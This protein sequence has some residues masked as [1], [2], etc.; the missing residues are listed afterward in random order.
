M[1]ITEPEF[2]RRA[3]AARATKGKPPVAEH[4]PFADPPSRAVPME[5][6]RTLESSKFLFFVTLYRLK[7]RKKPYETPVL[8]IGRTVDLHRICEVGLDREF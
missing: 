4:G 7:L 1:T 8:R 5:I 2:E 3:N 6:T